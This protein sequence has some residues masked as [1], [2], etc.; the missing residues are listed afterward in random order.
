M[1]TSPKVN[2]FVIK[3]V[4]I[5]FLRL[6]IHVKFLVGLLALIVILQILQQ[7]TAGSIFTISEA[8]YNIIISSSKFELG[9]HLNKLSMLI[10]RCF[11]DK[12]ERASLFGYAVGKFYNIHTLYK[13]RIIFFEQNFMKLL[14]M[15]YSS[16]HQNTIHFQ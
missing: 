16:I 10:F 8:I 7:P 5:D 2:L 15:Y 11:P 14:V 1:L 3:N 9:C 13:L 12:S 4:F 6:L